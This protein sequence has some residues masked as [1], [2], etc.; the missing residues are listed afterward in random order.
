MYRLDSHK[1]IYHPKRVSNWLEGK[2][3]YPIYSEISLTSSCNHR[4]RFCAPRFFLDY[5]PIFMETDLI[6]NT[7]TNMANFGV[8]AIMFGGEGE[9]LLHKDIVKI[10]KHTKLRG[11]DIALTTN[12]VLFNRKIAEKLLPL[13]SWIKFS[14]DSGNGEI[15]SYLHGTKEEDFKKVLDN[16]SQAVFIRK[17]KK[18]NC[19]IGVQCILFKDNIGTIKDLAKLLKVSHPDYL[20]VKPYSPHDKTKDNSLE[21]PTEKQI[22][23]LIIDMKEYEKDFKFI[24]R[25]IAFENKDKNK[26]YDKCYGKDFMSYIDTTGGVYSCINYIGNKSFCYGNIYDRP[27]SKIWSNKQEIT[28]DINKCRTICRLDNVNRYLWELK[29]PDNDVNFI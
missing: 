19:N 24:Y 22:E 9:P 29:N 25:D 18:Y 23:K 2:P 12:G 20:V 27:F 11:I 10:V 21:P 7:I 26:C 8:K 28:P 13:L 17:L 5:K 6:L 3:I 14:I 15:Y 1:L 16:I 4:C